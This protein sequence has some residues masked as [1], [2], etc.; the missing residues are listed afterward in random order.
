[1]FGSWSRRT[2]NSRTNSIRNNSERYSG[3]TKQ[4]AR[5]KSLP[6]FLSAFAAVL[7]DDL[8]EWPW[9]EVEIALNGQPS[10]PA[11]RLQFGETE[12]APLLLEAD[13]VP[14]KHEVIAP[15]TAFGGE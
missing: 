11:H 10:G 4:R 5:F 7:S 15:R 13:R 9:S 3:S 12:I 14:E 8:D 6:V 2:A 1:M